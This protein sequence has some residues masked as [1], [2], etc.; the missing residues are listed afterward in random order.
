MGEWSFAP[1]V[2]ATYIIAIAGGIL[3]AYL[4]RFLSSSKSP[5]LFVSSHQGE[6][7]AVAVASPLPQR[8]G[9]GD[10]G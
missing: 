9:G 1:G 5:K 4:L 2:I 3:L 7:R 8:G 10:Y 6:L